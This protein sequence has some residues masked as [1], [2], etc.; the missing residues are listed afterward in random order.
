MEIILNDEDNSC[1]LCKR[2]FKH[3]RRVISRVDNEVILIR[4]CLRCRKVLARKRVLED[5]LL[6]VEWTI[7]GLEYHP[8]Y[9]EDH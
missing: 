3:K 7:F 2:F 4:H 9:F 1:C 5:K 6:D 8:D